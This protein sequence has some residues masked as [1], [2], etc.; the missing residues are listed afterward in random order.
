[1]TQQRNATNDR[2]RLG[3]DELRSQIIS[4]SLPHIGFDGWSLSALE[5]GTQE[6]GLAP[7]A[8]LQA[9][10]NGP[11][12]AFYWYS[13]NC[14][15]RMVDTLNTLDVSSMR[16]R[17]RIATAVRIRLEILEPHRDAM[18]R[19]ATFLALPQNGPLGLRCLYHT[20]DDIWHAA[21]D[22]ATDYNF[23]T[24]RLLLAGVISS[25]TVYWLDDRSDGFANSWAFLDRRI[26]D[27]MKVPKLVGRIS[28]AA[29]SF[30]SRPRR[31]GFA[32][33]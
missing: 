10:P 12:E 26:E 17:E 16:I 3:L 28:S 32:R 21:G 23:Y 22:T 20:V 11:R 9:F 5:R 29:K 19:A 7:A 14:D 4:A 6:A 2:D 8:T 33:P 27:V 13:R 18:R 31:G 25:T 15:Q 30:A 1:M 24:K